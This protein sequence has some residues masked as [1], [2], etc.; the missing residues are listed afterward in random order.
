MT[1]LAQIDFRGVNPRWPSRETVIRW[2]HETT[3]W[4][5]DQAVAYNARA[6]TK[7][8]RNTLPTSSYSPVG[9]RKSANA[10][11]L[12]MKGEPWE[13]E[14]SEALGYQLFGDQLYF[15]WHRQ[16]RILFPERE[17]PLRMMNWEA[18]TE[19]M[20]TAFILGWVTVGTYQGYLVHAALNCAYQ[21]EISYESKH[22]RG[23][24]FMLRLF[25][26]WCGNVNHAW[27]PFAQEEPI[28][29]G[30]LER[31]RE[32]NPEALKPWLIAACDRHTYEALP[33]TEDD[34]HDFSRLVHVPLE[35]LLLFRLRELI[36][37]VNPVLE[38]PLMDS[39]FNKLP[40]P[41]P[42]YVPDELMRGTLARVREDWPK[43]D[44]AVSLEA[45]RMLAL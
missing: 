14:M 28:Y 40:K 24:A 36:G 6:D 5:M 1:E 42:P 18:M 27:P 11:A 8:I 21:L 2:I 45:V 16:F 13:A 25:A 12:A 23:H 20:A 30:I 39:P 41:A 43:F 3:P 9:Y 33:D 37:L 17:R 38:H 44:N 4:T 35:I 32:P 7:N 29:E 10:F 15:F 26:S 31:W 22:R 19:A 34:F